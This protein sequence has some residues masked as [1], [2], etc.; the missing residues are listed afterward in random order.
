ME[1]PY[2]RETPKDSPEIRRRKA[3]TRNKEVEETLKILYSKPVK[4][5]WEFWK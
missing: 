5:W 2:F 4:K 1:K 3:T